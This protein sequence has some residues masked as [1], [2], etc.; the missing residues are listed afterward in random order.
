MLVSLAEMKSYLNETT[1]TYDSFLTEQLTMISDAVEGYCGRK[2]LT[3]SYV[4]TFYCEDYK[5]P[6]KELSLFHYPLK[7]LTSVVQDG[8]DITTYIRK[9]LPYALLTYVD[10]VFFS[11]GAR[12]IVATYSAGT[13]STPGPVKSVVYSLVEERYNKKKSGV[14]LNF[15]SDVQSISIPGAIS[16]QFDYSL[17]SN[18]RKNA[19]G[20]LLGNYINVLDFYRSEKSV[21]GSGVVTYVV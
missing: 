19:F 5:R 14:S 8:V 3:A 4:E 17:Q 6:T 1:N 18:E 15:G 10:G 7:T 20:T 13:D 9:Q 11:A 2:F 16:I 21:I 12:E